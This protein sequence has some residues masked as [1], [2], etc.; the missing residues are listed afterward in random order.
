[1]PLI[2]ICPKLKEGKGSGNPS[3]PAWRYLPTVPAQTC[4]W[5]QWWIR[6]EVIPV[7]QHHDNWASAFGPG[8]R[9]REVMKV[10]PKKGRFLPNMPQRIRYLVSPPASNLD[11]RG[12]LSPEGGTKRID[13]V[14][15]TS[16]AR[17]TPRDYAQ[18][19]RVGWRQIRGF[20]SKFLCKCFRGR[21]F[22]G[23]N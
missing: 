17:L 13:S 6:A 16:K 5:S 12:R 1:M 23:T 4:S 21:N 22:L 10:K 14:H 20:Y 3:P 15:I 7:R 18:A 9:G 8:L 11:Q 2:T 19:L